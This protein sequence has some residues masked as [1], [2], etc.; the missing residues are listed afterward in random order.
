MNFPAGRRSPAFD[1]VPARIVN[2]AREHP[3]ISVL[4]DSRESRVNPNQFQP[5]QVPAGDVTVMDVASAAQAVR[6][7]DNR[8]PVFDCRIDPAA[9]N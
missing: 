3:A 6:L 7:V 9:L 8:P 2:S 5:G 4:N 1:G